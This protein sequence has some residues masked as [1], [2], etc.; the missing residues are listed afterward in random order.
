MFLAPSAIRPGRLWP[1]IALVFVALGISAGVGSVLMRASAG[2]TSANLPAV[3]SRLVLRPH[4]VVATASLSNGAS[5]RMTISPT[6]PGINTVRLT[7]PRLAQVP[8]A[9]SRVMVVARMMGMVMVPS[10]GT[11]APRAQAYTGALNL[12]MFG[13]Y[14]LSF[15]TTT[16]A[17]RITGHTAV[18]LPLP[19]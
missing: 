16:G 4:T 8:L 18:L 15:K 7:A 19:R 6:L 5:F 2:G 10:H 9:G 12:P 17:T 1:L 14:T 11:L 13:R 3:D